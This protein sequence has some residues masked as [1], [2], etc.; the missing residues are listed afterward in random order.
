M[1]TAQ[2]PPSTEQ[3]NTVVDRL[4]NNTHQVGFG[5]S[6]TNQ[7]IV[8]PFF[9]SSKTPSG[10]D[11][12]LAASISMATEGLLNAGVPSSIIQAALAEVVDKK[13]GKK[14]SSMTYIMPN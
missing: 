1:G 12:P 2:D 3:L 13:T 9:D 11:S 10:F 14:K 7:K 4:S 8:G 6:F 5:D